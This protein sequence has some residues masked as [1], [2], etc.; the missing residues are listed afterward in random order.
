MFD[1]HE[2]NLELNMHNRTLTTYFR[3]G[4]INVT[5]KNLKNKQLTDSCSFAR[6]LP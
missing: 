6:S 4:N 1:I 2:R 5:L 3:L